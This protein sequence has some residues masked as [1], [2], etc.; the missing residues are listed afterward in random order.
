[1]L[2]EKNF[3][4][5]LK[6][7]N[8][9]E[10]GTSYEKIFA[11]GI[12][13][14]A[15][16]AAKKLSYPEQLKGRERNTL[17]EAAHKENL[18][19]F[20]CVNRLLDKG[21]KPADIEL[22]KNWQLGHTQKSGRADI[23][24]SSGDKVLFIIE[25][26]TAGA[27][28]NHELD[29]MRTDGGQLFSYWQQEQSCQWL[30]LYA[31]DFVDG[32]L[33]FSAA[34]VSCNE[35]L[36][37]D[38][39]T[40]PERF[41]VWSD[42]CEKK[43]LGDVIFHDET[44]AYQI[45]VKPLRKRDLEDFSRIGALVNKFEEILRHNQVSNKAN[46]FDVLIAL[47]ICKL[48]D[49]SKLNDC[50]EVSFQ[51]KL[52][53]DTHYSFQDRL[54]KLY[55]D[56]M[57]KFMSEDIFYLPED[58]PEKL[59]KNFTDDENHEKQIQDL[60]ENFRNL[61]YFNPNVF[62]FL[63]VHNEILFF[64]NS[65]ILAEVV[66]MLQN[67]FIIGSQDLQKLGD[68]FEQL[69]NKGF[70]Q[71]EGQFFTPIPITRFIWDSLPLDEII[72]RNGLATP[73]KIIDYACGAG[74]FL[75]EGFKAVNDC[76]ARKNLPPPVMWERDKL[77]GVEKD[78]RLSTVSKVSLFMHGANEGKIKFGDGL[79][80]YPDENISPATFDILVANP[81]Y[82]VKGFKNYLKLSNNALDV[83]NKISADGSEIETLFVERISQL[84]K[85]RGVAA[86]ILPGSILNK[87]GKSFVAARESLLKNFYIRAIVQLGS[88]TFG[89]TGTNTVVMFL[90]RF[91]EPPRFT[92]EFED[93]AE[94]IL[95]GKLLE[96][97][98]TR[99][100]FAAYTK[101]IGVAPEV[102]KKFIRREVDFDKW[103][104]PYFAAYAPKFSRVT[105]KNISDA[106]RIRRNN[107]R[108]YDA[109]T[110][111][112]R[113]KI[114]YFALTY[115]QQTLIISAPDNNTEQEKFLGYGWSNAKGR[116]G[117][118][119]KKRGGLLF[120]NEN[121]AAD[122]TLA[123]VIRAAYKGQRCQIA[124]LEKYFHYATLVDLLDF[125]AADFNKKI[126]LGSSDYA[127]AEYSGTFPLVKLGSIGKVSMCKRIM[128]AETLEEGEIPFY[129]I[130]TFG[131]QPDAYITRKKFEE[132]RKNYPYPKKGDVLISAAGTIGKTFVFDGE[133]AYFQDSNI[134]WVDN[135]E[136]VLLNE[137]LHCFYSTNPW[138][139]TQGST[140]K[141][142]YN[143]G[144]ENVYVPAPPLDVQKKIVDEFNALD[145]QI[146]A[147]DDMLQSLDADIKAKFAALFDGKN[148]PVRKLGEICTTLSGG[149][150]DTKNES[151][152]SGKIPWITTVA[153][154]K[155]FIDE[156]DAASYITEEAIEKSSTHLIPA[157]TLLFGVRVGVGKSSITKVSICTNQDIVALMDV[158]EQ[159]Y[160]KIFLKHV[161]D[162][163]QKYFNSIKRGMT[164]KGIT[165]NDLKAV[166]IP[167][168]PL[169]LQEEFA[170]YVENCEA[171]KISARAKREE[172]LAERAALVT[173]YF[174]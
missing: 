114:I 61:K 40:V 153:L 117:L 81:P 134:V 5:I 171:I 51:F 85:S 18:V 32:K 63:K 111:L 127:P 46:A 104:A 173:K 75:T 159:R 25:C 36:Y 103:D 93:I 138:R 167:D 41:K 56:G 39:H 157:N 30:M 154:G 58:Y 83:L 132:Y 141:R 92:A 94:T 65:K 113:E 8:F 10:H 68:L 26:K 50:D 160:N 45:G 66:E 31:S 118:I 89:A 98:I 112:E 128:K 131:G 150:P 60:R 79:E 156:N 59:F 87:D 145:L 76:Y 140:I 102:Y 80:N 48:E 71:D 119:D 49:E 110:E 78:D 106:E 122:N 53:S 47:F 21:Y 22:E 3:A 170:A 88:K 69:L 17:I 107:L 86:V 77:F 33:K 13:M 95:S 124:A 42:H 11:E 12:V 6:S 174:R 149:T 15:D 109:V 28:Y 96:R 4:Q 152:Y 166:R 38:A 105:V 148:F 64:M 27:E 169:E 57:K 144:I 73:P 143:S 146:A 1:M 158:D 84:V 7:M 168:A 137:Y 44:R 70:K 147:Q 126:T 97:R 120:D 161:L 133:P 123:A 130:G 136:S 155:I 125:D 162:A 29:N 35:K 16:L 90:E 142:L 135:D 165:S 62:T 20:E 19:V 55:S 74:H 139:V 100:I 67:Y 129:K 121:R 52:K 163:Y 34:S 23:C 108:F 24:V 72:F 9:I 164:I 115:R 2:T 91:D 14:K 172:L 37:R 43:F 101:K 82:S 116:E 99:E 151:F 54:Q